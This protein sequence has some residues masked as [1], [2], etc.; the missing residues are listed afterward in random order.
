MIVEVIKGD[1][2]QITDESKS[3][4]K[5]VI[6]GQ[7]RLNGQLAVVVECWSKDE[8]ASRPYAE[9]VYTY[10]VPT[11]ISFGNWGIVAFIYDRLMKE[12]VV[13][14]EIEES[15]VK[16]FSPGTLISNI[17]IADHGPRFTNRYPRFNS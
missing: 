9:R 7:F 6:R 1:V 14:E 2:L 4:Y 3:W 17:G 11:P 5:L 15:Y 10:D 16:W 13:G 12:P 8:T